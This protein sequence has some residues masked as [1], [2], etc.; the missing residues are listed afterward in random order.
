MD[1]RKASEIKQDQMYSDTRL[2][3]EIMDAANDKK[4][5]AYVNVEL[6]EP[7]QITKLKELGYNLYNSGGRLEISWEYAEYDG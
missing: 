7:E 3:I 5:K 4:C 1:L 6:V 2:A